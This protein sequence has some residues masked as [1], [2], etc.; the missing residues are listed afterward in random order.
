MSAEAIMPEKPLHVRTAEA[1]GWTMLEPSNLM[2]LSHPYRGYPPH[3]PVV[4]QKERVPYYDTDWSATGPLIE[5]YR[6]DTAWS[7][8]E[9]GWTATAWRPDGE[10]TKAFYKQGST[11]L[12]A[13]CRLIIVLRE[14]GKLPR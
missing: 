5:Q 13:V 14:T 4:G 6:F 2:D 8:D 3:L 10:P 7:G 11:I 1:L 9:H 12:I